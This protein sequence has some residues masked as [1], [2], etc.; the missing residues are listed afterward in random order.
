VTEV[1]PATLAGSFVGLAA[2]VPAR[3][4]RE[5]VAVR[6]GQRAECPV[7][8]RQRLVL[9]GDADQRIGVDLGQITEAAATAVATDAGKRVAI[10]RDDQAIVR[11]PGRRS[12]R[13]GRR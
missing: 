4:L 5:R 12:A 9:A 11:L 7:T 10:A 2:D 3:A 13:G 8:A 6:S 1:G